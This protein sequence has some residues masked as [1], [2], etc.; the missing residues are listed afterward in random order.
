TTRMLPSTACSGGNG[1]GP[2]RRRSPRARPKC[3]RT[4]SPSTV[5]ACRA[6][7]S[8]R[9]HR[10]MDLE[11]DP[12]QRL[13]AEAARA[14][15]ARA[16]PLAHV[17]AMEVDER[18]FSRELW[19]EMAELGWLGMELPVEA[20]GNGRSFLDVAL[21]CEEMGRALLPAPFLSTCVV[22]APLL[23]ELGGEAAR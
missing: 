7:A 1:C 9:A 14:F 23:A 22:A 3:R 19:R 4:S 2:S 17:R 8:G 11:L 6:H 16:C 12:E 13:L 20:G 21:L 18:G 15:L 10:A 5:S